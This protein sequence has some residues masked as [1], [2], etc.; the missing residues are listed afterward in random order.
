M[1]LPIR[2]LT[3][4]DLRAMPDDGWRHEIIDGELVVSPAPSPLHQLLVYVLYGLL[5]RHVLERELG[6]VLG[7]PIDVKFNDFFSL[8]P[9]ICFVNAERVGIVVDG[10]LNGAPDLVV[11]V[12]SPSTTRHD[13]RT[14]RAAYERFGVR[15]YWVLDPDSERLLVHRLVDGRYQ[16][17]LDDQGAVRSGVIDGFVLDVPDLFTAVRRRLNVGRNI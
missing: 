17:A 12:L 10:F 7:A 8:Q 13:L 14:K 15:E 2:K 11:E 4:D 1:A 9:D 5:D 6:I 16:T 3:F